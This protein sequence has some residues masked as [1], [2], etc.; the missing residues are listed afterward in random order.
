MKKV[1]PLDDTNL[2]MHLLS[3]CLAKWQTQYDLTKKMTPVNTR[4]LLLVLE[5][6]ENNAEVEAKPHSMIKPK[7]AKGKHRME[8][9][10]SHI[11]KKSKQVGFSNKQCALCKAWRAAR[12]AQH[13]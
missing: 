4:T 13:S 8:S 7:G 9:I 10:N 12:M 1:L 11:P 5:K 2:A 6:I 3:M